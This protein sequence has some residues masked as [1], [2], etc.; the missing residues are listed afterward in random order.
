[1][2]ARRWLIIGGIVVALAVV[3]TAVAV[4]RASPW[5]RDEVVQLLSE[6]LDSEVTLES[7]EVSLLPRP[8]IRGQGLVVR[9]QGRTDIP[10]FIVIR[11]FT[12]TTDI[13]GVLTKRAR[14]VRLE[15]LEISV[16]PR[17]GDDLPSVDTGGDDAEDGDDGRTFVDRL[18]ADNT[19]L[20]ILSK[21]PAKNPKVFDIFRLEMLDVG[22]ASP[23][24]FTATLT[25][26]VPFG[27]IDVT[28]HFGPW[29]RGAPSLTP[30]DGQF[31]FDA[32]LGTIKGVAG[33]LTSG[34]SFG[35]VL[36][37]IDANGATTTPDFRL[38]TLPAGPVPLE[39]RYD[40][41][42]DGTSGDVFLTAVDA[43]LGASTFTTSG[44]IVGEE[45]VKG[46]RITLDVTSDS[47]RIEDFMRLVVGTGEPFLSGAMRFEARIDIRQGDEDVVD[48]LWIDGEFSLEDARFG[49][50]AVQAKVDDLSRRGQGRPEDAAIDNVVSDM[51]GE[52][53]L[54]DAQLILSIITFRVTG[55]QVQMAGT[56]GLRGGALDFRGDVR[57]D[58]PVSDTV[59]G[60][61]SWL[62]KP[63]N[64]LFRKHGA[65]TRVAIKVAGTTKEPDVGVEIGRTLRGQ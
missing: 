4:R 43:R 41:V 28:G 11:E 27:A 6:H 21:D 45:G 33:H 56:Y 64:A 65:G 57:L 5:V 63:F 36:E 34:G 55:A 62:L 30:L 35:G 40:A 2:S 59:S 48:K 22:F 50:G 12:G 15:G 31:E 1:M 17:R 16:P 10:P 23:A 3:T 49:S 9:Y 19:R 8:A 52:F 18:V 51:K 25:N 39:T 13:F 47:S 14:D 7:L 32:D 60:F 38:P 37:R 53:S 54:K 44:A 20:S 42:I 58:V 46:K 26:P 24:P 29:R 61:K